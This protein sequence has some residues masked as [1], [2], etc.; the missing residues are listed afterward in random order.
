[1]TDGGY[2]IYKSWI[3]RPTDDSDDFPGQARPDRLARPGGA[4]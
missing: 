2:F 3:F 4:P 1:M